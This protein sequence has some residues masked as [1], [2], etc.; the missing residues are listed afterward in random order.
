MVL[1]ANDPSPARFFGTEAAGPWLLTCEHAGHAVPQALGDLGLARADLLD[2]IGWDPG[3]LA[4]AEALADRLGARGVAQPYSRLV[5]DCNRPAAAPDLMPAISDA[6][7]VPG[8]DGLSEAARAARWEQIHQPY[9]AAVAAARVGRSALVSVH[10]FTARKQGG[11]P[12][13]TEIGV[14]ARDGN[15]LFRHLMAGLSEAWPGPVVANDPYEIEDDSDYTI[16]VHAEPHGLPHVLL[17]VRNDLLADDA[18]VTR[19]AA[20]LAGVLKGFTP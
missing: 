3:A 9:H 18:G 11:A 8:N 1:S 2:H 16:P 7:L 6:R 20:A 5:I 10:S 4:L 19:V 17:E 14:L 13:T 12:R 15:A